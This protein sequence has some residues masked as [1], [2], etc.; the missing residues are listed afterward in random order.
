MSQ[1]ASQEFDNNENF[2]D[3]LDNYLGEDEK[4]VGKVIEGE[5]V[6]IRENEDKVLI[7]IG[8][9]REPYIPLSE[10]QDSDGNISFQKGDKLKLVV[11]NAQDGNYRISHKKFLEQ[12][13]TRKF[14]EQEGADE[15]LDRVINGSIKSVTKR[16][17]TLEENG[18]LFFMPH[19][20]AFLQ[21]K[22]GADNRRLQPDKKVKAKIFKI[23]NKKNS[24]IVSR[25]QYIRDEIKKRQE[26]I[27]EVKE[28]E[29]TQCKV[30]AVTKDKLVVD[31]DDGKMKGYIDAEEISHRGKINPF[32]SYQR[33]DVV[34]AKVIDYDQKERILNLSIK[35]ITVDPWIEIQESIEPGDVIEVTVSNIEHYGAFVDIGNDA[36]GFLHVS[37]VAWDKKIEHPKKYITVG[38]VIEVEVVEIDPEAHRLRVSRKK[39]LPKP[40]ELFEQNRRVGDVITGEVVNVREFG[41]FIKVD[42]VE[43]LLRNS[44]YD[45]NQGSKCSDHLKTGDTVEVKVHEIDH[46]NEKVSLS[47]KALLPTPIQEFAKTHKVGDIVQG[48]IRDIK[49]FGAFITI[50][51][52]VDAL[53]RTE[54]MFPKNREEFEE[55]LRSGDKANREKVTVE[56]M[57]IALDPK[58]DRLR[59]SIKRLEKAKEQ[60]LLR[61]INAENDQ[62]NTLG[63]LL[64]EQF[65]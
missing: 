7:G 61:E 14:I 53:I 59:L 5:I 42:Q 13:I 47:R 23:D 45:W 33:G 41:A 11:T 25:K 54:D 32:R 2:A 27:E 40:F 49:E 57:I 35:A 21:R 20:Q 29:S 46:K 12:E 52:N 30:I 28:R 63:E 55:K 60:E 51:K 10:I 37:E 62:S 38:D 4:E 1:E 44:Y 48:T 56:G 26:F 6:E 3:M 34:E 43:G 15:L 8:E 19:N 39:L 31:I 17:Y 16:G 24:I 65:K 50:G 22:G 9:K 36:E 18:I 58:R 64:K